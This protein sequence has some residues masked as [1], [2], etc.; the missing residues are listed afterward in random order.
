MNKKNI[1]AG[2]IVAGGKGV[3]VGGK[4]PKQFLT[5]KKI[6]VFLWSVIA[7]NKTT[8]FSQLIVVAPNK[9]HKI[10]AKYS[11]KHNF[12]FAN[13]GN[14]RFNSVI[15][16]LNKLNENIGF[17]AIHDGA[18]PFVSHKLITNTT[19]AAIKNGAAIAAIP[20]QDTV[21]YSKDNYK[22]EKTLPR[23]DIWLAQTPQTFAKDIIIKAYMKNKNINITDDSSAVELLG[24][25]PIL[26]SGE[27][28]NFKITTK[29][30]M[31]LAKI[32]ATKRK[33]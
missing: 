10:Y 11:K 3:R 33:L 18:R 20:A 22:I 6:P 17:V 30:D 12:T 25:K 16:G 23:K 28:N 4:T 32:I 2:I 13:A 9:Y 29:E 1:N 19:F 5:L 21:K 31:Q 7:F 24:I 26:I 8:L 14:E 27:K 15:S